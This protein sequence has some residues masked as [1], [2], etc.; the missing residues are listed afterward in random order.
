MSSIL[1]NNGAMIALQTLKGINSSLSKTQSEISTGKSV[2]SAKDNA[3]T[4]AISKVMEADVAGFKAISDSLSLGESTVAVARNA[5]ETVTDLLKEIKGKITSSQEANVDRAKI[6]TDIKALA[7][8]IKSVTG[9]A[10]FNGLNLI[11]GSAKNPVT[12]MS[13]LDR[14]ANGAM[15]SSNI[16]VG[17]TNLSNAAGTAITS[18]EGYTAIAADT[19]LANAGTVSLAVTFADATGTGS[20]SGALSKDDITGSTYSGGLIADDVITMKVGNVEASYRVKIG[21]N[22]EAVGKGLLKALN[23]VGIKDMALNAAGD[24]LT[25]NGAATTHSLEANRGRGDMYALS[26]FDVTTADGAKKALAEVEGL[27]QK[28]IDAASSFGS[29]EKR[30]SIQ[31][32]FVSKLTD[33]M[34]SGIGSLV[35]ANMEET[36]ARLQALQT[37]QQLG[38]QALSMANQAPQSILSLFR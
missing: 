20:G 36:S 26:K 18:G 19:A 3:A 32:D 33:S 7:D 31:N 10:Q 27:L 28:S 13:S 11:D 8:Q 37:Q 35:D 34:K 12:V 22:Q 15:A 21:D 4:W 5:T 16:D 30:I 1:T 29:V 9:A 17:T 38:I 14:G 2:A 25:N 6:Q 23:E 24:T